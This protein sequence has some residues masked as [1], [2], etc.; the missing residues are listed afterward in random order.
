MYCE[1]RADL[2]STR[3]VVGQG[4]MRTQLGGVRW[5]IRGGPVNTK[6][7]IQGWLLDFRL[8]WLSLI[9][10]NENHWKKNRFGTEIKSYVLTMLMLRCSQDIQVY[11]WHR[12]LAMSLM[13]RAK[14][15]IWASPQYYLPTRF[16]QQQASLI[17]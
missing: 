7:A 3:L 4:K 9:Y 8:E 11:T 10:C 13:I 2:T 16:R 14:G 1:D 17:F 5:A 15:L 12:Q 6:W